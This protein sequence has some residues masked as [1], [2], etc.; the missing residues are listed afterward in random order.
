[1]NL[2]LYWTHMKNFALL[3]AFPRT[4]FAAPSHH[5]ANRCLTMITLVMSVEVCEGSVFRGDSGIGSSTPPGKD[6]LQDSHV[7]SLLPS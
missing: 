7:S 5:L 2:T 3:L 1:M 4:A 6:S